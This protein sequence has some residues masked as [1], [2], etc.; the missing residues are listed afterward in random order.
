MPRPEVSPSLP[1]KAKA[2]RVLVDM[3]PSDALPIQKLTKDGA[4]I[5]WFMDAYG[6]CKTM[7]NPT[8][9]SSPSRIS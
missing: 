9:V 7:S 1:D 6:R 8:K 3:R 5:Q 4:A 2:A